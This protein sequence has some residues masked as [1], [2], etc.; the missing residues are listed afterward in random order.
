[1]MGAAMSGAD[2]FKRT[3]PV[4]VLV[5]ILLFGA[6]TWRNLGRW[7]A[8]E[9]PH[10]RVDVL[11]VVAGAPD[12]R[13]PKAIALAD[14]GL[15]REIWVILSSEGPVLREPHAIRA[16]ARARHTHATM[17]F[18]GRS[19]TLI[20]DAH[21]VR[22]RLRTMSGG[23]R[24][25]AVVTAPLRLART[26]LVF[27]RTLGESVRVW[28]DGTPYNAG[29]WWRAQR[30]T[31]TLEGAKLLATFALIGPAPSGV[32]AHPSPLRPVRA[33]AGAVVVAF[34]VGAL[35]RVVARRMGFVA[36][37]RLWRAHSI[38]TPMLGGA[39]IVAGLVGGAVA[40]G[41]V[42]V[43]S[44]GVVAVVGIVV[45]ALV[46]L[47]DD[48]AG[49]G[50]RT[51]LI[52]AGVAGI[53]A[54][55]LGLRADVFGAGTVAEIGNIAL[56]LLWFVGITHALNVLD[57]IDGVTAGVGAAS[58]GTIA[59]VAALNGQTVVS[60]A[61]AALAG[62]CVGY[63]IHNVHP[64]RLFMGDM[65]ALALGF[66]LA[67]L[68]LALRSGQHPPLSF[69][70]LALVLGVPIFDTT[71]VTIS[72][73]R[74]GRRVALGGTD[75]SSHRLIA[76]GFSVR[77]AAAALWGVQVVLGLAA[78]ALNESSRAI[79]WVI[80]VVMGLSGLATLGF[81]LRMEPW[82]PPT[83]HHVS[84]STKRTVGRGPP[85]RGEV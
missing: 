20:K 24:T 27:R 84:E 45:L 40:S 16:Y 57:H 61:A 62:A 12:E 81:F 49:L 70:L 8:S 58:A 30:V 13:V 71:L 17:R 76:R 63:L 51:R 22:D 47:V 55:L 79:G 26:R 41:G 60:V 39:A 25:V 5:P 48:I 10:R 7:L 54:W 75:H 34:V 80:V 82:T 18:V 37:P 14:R 19:K 56:T 6:V 11:V 36:L 2:R 83:H 3:L 43:G 78:V 1:M 59:A 72:R 42:R 15:A 66:A 38:P 74:T 64:A 77:R 21:L 31:T 73:M 52:W 46:G 69:G 28:G 33:A 50:S 32:H 67:S 53:V 85:R 29:K 35:C 23:P 65:G 44:E 68:S 4:L 9:D